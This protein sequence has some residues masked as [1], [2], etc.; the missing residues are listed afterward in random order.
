VARAGPAATLAFQRDTAAE[1]ALVS[2]GLMLAATADR[3]ELLAQ[4]IA[5][6]LPSLPYTA[7]AALLAAGHHALG[8]SRERHEL[9]QGSAQAAP[10]SAVASWATGPPL[11]SAWDAPAAGELPK[12]GKLIVRR[13][14]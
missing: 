11:V 8:F 9:M 4:N 7:S 2:Y 10:A 1:V 14:S 6:A 12:S 5:T 13:C 3:A